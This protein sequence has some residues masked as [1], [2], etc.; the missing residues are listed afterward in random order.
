MLAVGWVRRT[1]RKAWCMFYLSFCAKRR[2]NALPHGAAVLSGV[3]GSV[4]TNAPSPSA[5]LPTSTPAPSQEK[6]NLNKYHSVASNIYTFFCCPHQFMCPWDLKM[7]MT[8]PSKRSPSSLSAISSTVSV[9]ST[10]DFPQQSET[11]AWACLWFSAV[12]L[13]SAPAL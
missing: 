5:L 8:V 11:F 3:G 4:P 13:K 12:G 2:G 6:K 10:P 1:W 9:G 7:W